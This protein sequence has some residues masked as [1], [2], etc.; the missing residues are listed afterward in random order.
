[1]DN[2]FIRLPE[3]DS[4]G[5]YWLG[6]RQKPCDPAI[7]LSKRLV[8]D[9]EVRSNNNYIVFLGEVRG[10][11]FDGADFKRFDKPQQALKEIIR[12]IEK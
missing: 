4:Y 12:Q 9:G 1:M 7:F 10:F 5:S 8:A 11:L 3:P 2:M 6:S